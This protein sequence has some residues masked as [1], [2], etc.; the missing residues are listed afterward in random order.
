MMLPTIHFNLRQPKAIE[1]TNIYCV[2]YVGGKQIKFA[3]SV[4]VKP[5]QKKKKK[6]ISHC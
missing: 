4:K 1:P 3:T 2:V 5:K 6:A